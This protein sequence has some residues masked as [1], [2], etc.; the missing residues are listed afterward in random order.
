MKLKDLEDRVRFMYNNFA[1]E[2]RRDQ[3]EYDGSVWSIGQVVKGTCR[4]YDAIHLIT[5]SGFDLASHKET[6]AFSRMRKL[7]F[8]Y[9]V[10]SLIGEFIGSRNAQ[11]DA[12]FQRQMKGISIC[13]YTAVRVTSAHPESKFPKRL[14]ASVFKL[15]TQQLL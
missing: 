11:D 13:N 2:F 9:R 14:D 5:P 12:D 15:K 8:E 10:Y 1:Y 6:W 3:Q 4:H 7:G